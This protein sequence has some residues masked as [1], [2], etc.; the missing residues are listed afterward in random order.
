[1]PLQAIKLIYFVLIALSYFVLLHLVLVQDQVVPALIALAVLV[2]HRVHLVHLAAVPA[3][4]PA[5]AQALQAP[6]QVLALLQAQALLLVSLRIIGLIMDVLIEK[7]LL[8]IQ[9]K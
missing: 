6:A 7:E 9:I 1:M 5:P 8:L 4:A 2:L 3:P